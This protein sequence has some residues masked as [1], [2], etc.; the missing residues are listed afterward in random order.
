MTTP[1]S[2]LPMLLILAATIEENFALST[3]GQN[4]RHTRI[5]SQQKDRPLLRHFG[6]GINERIMNSKE[7]FN[8]FGIDDHF[9]SAETI[10]CLD[11]QSSDNASDSSRDGNLYFS[12]PREIREAYTADTNVQEGTTGGDLHGRSSGSGCCIIRLQG[13][14]A[15]SVRGL[16]DF[17]DNFFEGVDDE[18]RNSNIKDLGVFRIGNNIHAGFDDDVN[19]EGKMQVL[20]TKLIPGL[21]R[22]DDPLLLPLEV[23]ELVGTNS[24][25]RAHSGMNTLFDIGSQITSA[26]LGMDSVTTSKLLDDCTRVRENSEQHNMVSDNADKIADEVSNSYQRIIRYLEPP[27]A[28]EETDPAFWPHV[29]STFLTLIP[30]PEIAGLEVWCPSLSNSESENLAHRGEWVRPVKPTGPEKAAFRVESNEEA[31]DCIHVVA[32]A[33]EFLQ[34]LSDGQ[35]PTCIHRVIAP[36]PPPPASSGFSPKKYKARVSAPLFLRPRRGED[37]ILDVESDLRVSSNNGLYF[38][39]GLLEECDSMRVWDYMH[40]I[41]PDN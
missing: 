5:N 33:G 8:R 41:S 12:S 11:M 19:E 31:D 24:L 35:V 18:K 39:K 1:L 2:A 38:E 28:V 25:S 9:T 36:K 27:A 10:P 14:D 40:C 32:L 26:V 4:Q 34:L 17:A 23:G 21:T 20:Y 30:M 3:I 16:M 37:A 15:A 7:G 6:K 29:D 13:K 22:E